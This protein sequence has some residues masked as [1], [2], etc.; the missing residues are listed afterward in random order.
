[1]FKRHIFSR[2]LAALMFCA[3]VCHAQLPINTRGHGTAT[4]PA[5]FFDDIHTNEPAAHIQ[6]NSTQSEVEFS[7][8]NGTFNDQPGASTRFGLVPQGKYLIRGTKLTFGADG[9]YRLTGTMAGMNNNYDWYLILT[10]DCGHNSVVQ[11]LTVSPE[12]HGSATIA[13]SGTNPAITECYSV[14]RVNNIHLRSL[15]SMDSQS[16]HLEPL[17][18]N[19]RKQVS[20]LE[21]EIDSASIQHKQALANDLKAQLKKLD[22]DF[23][24]ELQQEIENVSGV[25]AD[26]KNQLKGLINLQQGS[27]KA[28]L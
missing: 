16:Y 27:W 7:N 4:V 20:R 24:E 14:I 9:S 10:L 17:I 13:L 28:L 8:L 22:S 25:S 2:A 12:I 6:G 26:V 1:M 19:H 23:L 18:E 11:I 21:T 5:E 3:V 15:V